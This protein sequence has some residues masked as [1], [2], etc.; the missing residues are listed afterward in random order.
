MIG[1]LSFLLLVLLLLVL[2]LL[3]GLLILLL[4]ILLVFLF[5]D[6]VD[7]VFNNQAGDLD[8]SCGFFVFRVNIKALPPVT[9]AGLQIFEGLLQV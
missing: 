4:F 8:I 2:L 7:D 5:I 3:V 1:V 6:L 9:D